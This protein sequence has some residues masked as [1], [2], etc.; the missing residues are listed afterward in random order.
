[1]S[2]STQVNASSATAAP[3]LEV[4][5]GQITT[6]SQQIAAHFGKRHADVIRAI[7][8]ME[9]PDEYRERNFALTV[10]SRENPS[11]GAPISAPMYRITR[12]G[13]TLLAMG[14]TG[15][16]AMH[17]KLAYIEA[18]NKMEEALKNPGQDSEQVA[19]A[20]KAAL[21]ATAEVFQSVFNAVMD[22]KD[23]QLNRYM[24]S[25][26]VTAQ[27]GT[28]ARVK[29][30]ERNACVLPLSRFHDAIEDSITVDASTLTRLISVCTERLG[31][32]AQR[33]MPSAVKDTVVAA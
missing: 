31:R 17:W 7:K 23:W 28:V 21:L 14:F 1:M 19:L 24:L 12:D 8:K 4:V 6:T 2:D 26:D 10:V 5:G 18:F 29:P 22:A 9:I 32:M 33:A 20:R 15:K 3:A 30:I 11:G 25:F 27:E 13:F 16:T